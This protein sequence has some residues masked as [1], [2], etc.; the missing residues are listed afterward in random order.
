VEAAVTT[1]VKVDRLRDF[2]AGLFEGAGVPP[3][4]ALTVADSLVEADLRGVSS[5]G[6][7]RV[8]IYLERLQAGLINPR[9][10][11]SVVRETPTTVLLDGDNGLG[12]VVGV[13]AMDEAIRRATAY[14]TAW[15]SVRNSNHFGAAAYYVQ[16]AIAARCIGL[17]LTN[18]PATMALWGGRTPFLGTNP[19]AMGVP[20]GQ[21]R[22]IVVDMATSVAA[23]GKIILAAK[24]GEAI[25]PGLAVDV[26]GRPTTDAQAA[27][28]GA[29]LPFAQHKGYGIAL[30]IEMLSGV[31]AGATIAPTV[32]NLYDNPTGVQNLGHGF[33]AVRVDALAP[34]D[35]FA[36]R[37]DA[38]IRE[39]RQSPRG[40]GVPRIYL[41]GEIEFELAERNRRDGLAL[42]EPTVREL[43]ALGAQVGLACPF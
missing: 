32:G 4:D 19:F 41:P 35:E 16:R 40:A 43:S 8:G 22:P 17:A 30:L 33:G 14:G 26:E 39:V 31:L 29:V 37:M 20:A 7:T 10:T 34:I 12:A 9:P 42:A 11:V 21:E 24:K 13:W 5:H 38:L 25:P 28:D 1:R 27:L 15:V 6:T 3:A 2:C 18:A 36:D 23:R